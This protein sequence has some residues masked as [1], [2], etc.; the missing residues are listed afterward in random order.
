MSCK[1]YLS[2]RLVRSRWMDI[3]LVLFFGMLMDLNSVSVH[4]HAKK[5]LG[6]YPAILSEQAWLLHLL[7]GSTPC[8]FDRKV[9]YLYSFYYKMV[10]LSQT[11]ITNNN[12]GNCQKGNLVIYTLCLKYEMIKPCVNCWFFIF[13]SKFSR[14]Y[15]E[16]RFSIK[17]YV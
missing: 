1:K 10:T 16:W 4:K 17:G 13:P 3:G 15:E 12:T 7:R 11:F 2:N 14:G 8:K 9:P 5:W 6:Q